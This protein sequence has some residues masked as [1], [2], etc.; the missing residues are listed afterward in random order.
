M[1]NHFINWRFCLICALFAIGWVSLAT[2]QAAQPSDDFIQGY[3][4]A[5][6]GMNYPASVESIRVDDGE[7]Y[8]HGVTLLP[9]EQA[10]L[11]KMFSDVEGIVR[12]EIVTD[13]LTKK[14]MLRSKNI[15]LQ[16]R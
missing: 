7:V 2:V 15:I 5:I 4:N 14:L 10:R 6:V 16:I 9:E 13:I 11:H 12:I 8:L 1:D 3:V